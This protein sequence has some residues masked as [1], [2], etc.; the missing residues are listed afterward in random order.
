MCGADQTEWV[1]H[2]WQLGISS[3][4][5][6]RVLLE[7][8]QDSGFPGSRLEAGGS[9]MVAESST[10]TRLDWWK[11]QHPPWRT[12]Q[13]WAFTGCENAVPSWLQRALSRSSMFKRLAQVVWPD[14]YVCVVGWPPGSVDGGEGSR[15]HFVFQRACSQKPE[16]ETQVTCQTK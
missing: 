16:M 11:Q 8:P 2:N 9:S 14:R 7:L 1:I 13:C 12:G 6:I 5:H 10:K 15:G 3:S 4:S